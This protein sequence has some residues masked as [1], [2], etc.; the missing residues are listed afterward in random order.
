MSQE[1]DQNR[2]TATVTIEL[3]FAKEDQPLIAGV[4]KDIVSEMLPISSKGNGMP[5]KNSR[6]FYTMTS[7]QPAQPMTLERLFDMVDAAREPGEPTAAEKIMDSR[8]PE[9]EEAVAWWEALNDA[10]RGW[11]ISQYPDVK[12][13]S[14]AYQLFEGFD[15]ADKTILKIMGT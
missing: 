3:D 5:T 6:Y 15:E 2:I 4:L 11:F 14:K 9:Y 13:F 1:Q 8:H 12:L 10:Q 7:N